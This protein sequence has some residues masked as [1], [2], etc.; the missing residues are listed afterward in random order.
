[1]HIVSA[2]C[3]MLLVRRIEPVRPKGPAGA[4]P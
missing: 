4:Y 2:A 1:M 3:I